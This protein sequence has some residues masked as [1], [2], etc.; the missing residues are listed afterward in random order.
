M[1]ILYNYVMT[2]KKAVSKT[3][4]K[5]IKPAKWTCPNC[6]GSGTSGTDSCGNCKGKGTL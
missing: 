2:A 6:D 4:K 5:I 3:V 1:T